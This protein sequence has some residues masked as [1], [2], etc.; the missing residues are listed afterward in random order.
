VKETPAAKILRAICLTALLLTAPVEAEGQLRGRVPRLCFLTFDPGSL[1]ARSPRFDPFFTGLRDLGYIDGRNIDIAYLSADRNNDRFPSLI[2]QCL[3]LKP[4]VITVSTT[5]AALFVKKATR[6]VPTVM[7]GLGDPVG[8]GLVA[9]LSRPSEN[10]TGTSSMVSELGVKRLELLKEVAPE[11]SRVL[12]LTFLADDI[13]PLQI[14]ALERAAAS[15][16]M[17]LEIHDIRTAD[18]IPSAFDAGTRNGV[19]AILT[20]CESIFSVEQAQ[21]A[22]LAAQHRIPA[23]YCFRSAVTDA[24]GLM[25]YHGRISDLQ[26]SA[27]RYVDR[28]LK[29]A[30]VSE[31]PIEQPTIFDFVINLNAAKALNLTIPPTLLVRTTEVIE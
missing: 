26:R 15:L 23:A 17:A 16:G 31:L 4:D 21:I 11:I 10:V 2:D 6:T 25:V 30:K 5:P 12:V 8:A 22:N 20:T 7:I 28:I 13:A 9:S 3:A 24:G 29:G 1:D 27:A 18:D 14:K 19:H